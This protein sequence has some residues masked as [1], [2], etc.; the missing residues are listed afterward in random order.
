MVA[1]KNTV[2]IF[3]SVTL[4][5]VCGC[6]RRA[7][8]FEGSAMLPTIRPGEV[9]EVETNAYYLSKPKRWDVVAF[10]GPSTHK[11]IW[12]FRVVGLPGETVS[13]NDDGV[14][15]NG[16][17]LDMPPALSAIKYQLTSPERPAHA[18]EFPFVVPA[19][20]YF[21][22][23]DNPPNA[24]D[25]RMWGSVSREQIRGRVSGVENK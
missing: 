8:R 9:L 6:E 11:D 4:L 18:P 17:K 1:F 13:F 20:S 16:K 23:G 10:D 24:N 3:F 14:L 21:V 25:S 2:Y 7:V 12:F 19:D 22:I 15:I 5:F